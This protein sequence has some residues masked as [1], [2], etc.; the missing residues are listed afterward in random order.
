MK[1]KTQ[2]PTRAQIIAALREQAS[3]LRYSYQ[4]PNGKIYDGEIVAAI[5]CIKAAIRI[6]K[7]AAIIEPS[8]SKKMI[9]EFRAK[10]QPSPILVEG[11]GEGE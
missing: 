8:K 10:L 1:R 5:A 7:S 6:V 11:K 3:V 2:T 9:D 4:Y